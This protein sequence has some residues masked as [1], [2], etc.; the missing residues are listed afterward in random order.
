MSEQRGSVYRTATGYGIRWWQD[1]L[2]QHQSGFRTKT[3]ARTWFRENMAPR[4]HRGAPS[5]EITFGE[6]VEVFLRRHGATVSKRTVKT[7]EER[8]TPARGQFADWK[9]REL[10]GAAA[11]I[12][13]WRGTL[14]E[15]S[16]Y[17]LM[18]ALRQSLNAAVR[19]GY[20]GQNPAKL[21]GANPEPRAEEL[22]PFTVVEIDMLAAELGPLYGP[23]VVFAAETGLRTNEWVAVERRDL[24]R[25]VVTVQRRFADGV[26]TPYPKTVRSRR[27]VPL[28]DRANAAIKS[29]PPR[30]DTA[31]LFPSPRGLHIDLDNFRT[32]DFYPACEAAGIEPRG[33]Y[34]LRHTFATEALAAGV[35]LFE[36]SRLMGTSLRVID[37]THGHL[38][39]DSE[40]AI[41]R[42]LNARGADGR[43]MGVEDRD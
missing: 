11:D 21:A 41:V 12:A 7:L 34:H 31:L 39:S 43:L 32:R 29:V 1:G 24:D 15:T 4:L 16:R 35:S 9:L 10:E 13:A 23:L 20:L 19:W 42:R 2:R 6:F 17:R 22:R 27:R 28:T 8:L 25:A 40:D 3:E 5:A 18:L 30:L 26:M 38:A 37:R 33:P 14:A 36:L